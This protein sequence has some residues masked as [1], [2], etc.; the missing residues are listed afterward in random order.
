M[1]L[2][3]QEDSMMDHS[4]HIKAERPRKFIVS[5]VVVRDMDPNLFCADIMAYL[6]VSSIR[7]ANGKCYMNAS[8]LAKKWNISE[9][10]ARRT[11]ATTTR[12]CPR[13]ASQ[14][15][16]N[17]RYAYND[18]MLRYRHAPVNMFSDTMFSTKRVGKSI[19]NFTCAQVF[20]TDFGWTCIYLME[21][22]REIP[23]A[24]KSLFKD[25]CVPNKMIVDGARTQV[26]GETANTCRLAECTILELERGTPSANR[27]ERT[28]GELKTE[29]KSDMARA[30]SPIVMWC[31]CLKR[32]ARINRSIARENFQLN[33]NTPHSYLTGDTTDIS[34]I[35]LFD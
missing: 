2:D 7:F 20:A 9:R 19:R 16:L 4:G 35:C 15:T 21:Y 18:R 5:G 34:A 11:I 25:H 12:L 28:I 14:I 24:F 26:K 6:G 29:T 13:N 17:R 33:G 30:K 3:N 27:A 1:E 22:E 23:S 10:L 32:R 31:Y 8:E